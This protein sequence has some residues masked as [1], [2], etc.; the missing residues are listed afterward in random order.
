MSIGCRSWPQLQEQGMFWKGCRG[1]SPGGSLCT[2][3]ERAVTLTGEFGQGRFLL[4]V[5]WVVA[6]RSRAAPAVCQP[7]P[8]FCRVYVAIPS[9]V[10]AAVGFSR[11]PMWNCMAVD[12]RKSTKFSS[13]GGN[14]MSSFSQLSFHLSSEDEMVLFG[15][16]SLTASRHRPAQNVSLGVHQR[17]VEHFTPSSPPGRPSQQRRKKLYIILRE[18]NQG[19][20][21][22]CLELSH[23]EVFPAK[24]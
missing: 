23:K 6:R 24:R 17:N 4:V 19:I 21:T 15:S 22:I 13:R 7:S 12:K 11:E 16:Y 5:P 14:Q 3:G 10:A 1:E 8:F 18:K 20:G 2:G 9:G